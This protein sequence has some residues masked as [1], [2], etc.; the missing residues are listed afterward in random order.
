MDRACTGTTR[1]SS[2]P[3]ILPV[4][5]SYDV[6]LW[7]VALAKDVTAS[8]QGGSSLVHREAARLFRPSV[9]CLLTPLPDR[10]SP[11]P[12]SHAAVMQSA[13][14]SSTERSSCGEDQPIGVV[15]LH[16]HNHEMREQLWTFVARLG[17]S[18]MRQQMRAVGIETVASN[19][20][21]QPALYQ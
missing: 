10:R 4:G 3:E 21:L 16:A 1:F 5:E 6:W 12:D 9:S 8:I 15:R 18:V 14:I 13:S 19:R 17:L 7:R 20:N 11:Q 2:A